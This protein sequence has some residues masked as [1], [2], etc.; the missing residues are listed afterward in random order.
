MSRIVIRPRIQIPVLVLIF[1]VWTL[2]GVTYFTSGDGVAERDWFGIALGCLLVTSGMAG[3]WRALRLG[4]VVGGEGVR[5]RGFDS[6]DQFTPW[7][8]IQSVDCMQVDVRG[9]L[10]LYA[11]VLRLGG[12]ADAMPLSAL[13]SYSRQDAERKVEELRSLKAGTADS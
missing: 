4:V 2:V 1:A 7:S 3:I 12:D 10:P 8:S 9:G 5:V 6:R 11:P 13:G